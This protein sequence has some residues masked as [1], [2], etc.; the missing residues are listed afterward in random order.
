MGEPVGS[1]KAPP[2]NAKQF[3]SMGN[4]E[5]KMWGEDWGSGPKLTNEE[6]KD[7]D[8]ANTNLNKCTD[9][10]LKAHK[11]NMEKKFLANAVRPGDAGYK[12]DMR[13]K[14]EYDAD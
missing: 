2:V 4:K 12:Y 9:E 14:Y 3:L 10:E 8:Y 13:V 11:A 5:P 1:T 7:F 6:M